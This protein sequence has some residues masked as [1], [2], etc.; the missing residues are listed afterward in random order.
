[1]AIISVVIPVYNV[2]RYLSRCLT[3]VMSQTFTDFD[4]V[5]VDDGSTDKS[6]TM[7][8][9]VA[10][11]DARIHVIHQKNAGLSMARNMG[12]DWAKKN[13][14]SEWITFIDSDD[15]IHARYLEL[16]HA[17]AIENNVQISLC[18]FMR[19]ND[20]Q[21]PDFSEWRCRV[22]DVGEYYL[23]NIVNATVAWGKL[24]TKKA[25]HKLRYPSGKIH[26]DEYV[27]YKIL[28]HYGRVAVVDQPMYAYYQ[29]QEGIMLQ[30]WSVKR[31]D[32]LDA[33]EEQVAYFARNSM[34]RIAADRF[35]A[36]MFF[37]RTYQDEINLCD[38]LTEEAKKKY[39]LQLKKRMRRLLMQ[40][41]NRK[42]I[43]LKKRGNHLVVY[44]NA[45]PVLKKI[46]KIWTR[47]K[48]I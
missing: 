20:G 3:S 28:F 38:E 33:L 32:R 5:L 45:Y 39:I 8:D 30:K 17:A 25:F 27:T 18:P 13:S 9:E 2:E 29:N 23:E 34:N 7:C 40:Y 22:Y 11:S 14:D 44:E 36:L 19:I 48:A 26:E 6:R 43:S 10:R 24:Y 35:W 15:W 47:I 12:I 16:L 1:M 21:L 42:W 46:H 31:F 4:I 41:R 37:L